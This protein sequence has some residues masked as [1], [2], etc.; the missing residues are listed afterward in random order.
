[1]L[2]NNKV[3]S[4]TARTAT[5]NISAKIPED[6]NKIIGK[7]TSLTKEM[8]GITLKIKYDK[9]KP[10]AMEKAA[11]DAKNTA[12][13]MQNPDKKIKNTDKYNYGTGC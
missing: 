12:D 7:I 5:I 11:T 2:Q 1:M 4:I 3:I 6:L 10:V 13:K 8:P 9:T